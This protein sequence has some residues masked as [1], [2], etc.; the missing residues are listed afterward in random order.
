MSEH[1][2]ERSLDLV[3]YGASGFT[4]RQAAL[5][6]AKHAPAGLRWA[7]A[8]RNRDKLA[9]VRAELGPELAELPLIVAEGGDRAALGELAH[10]TRVV[11]TTAGPFALHGTALVEACVAEGTDYVDITGETVWVREL[12][13]AHHEAAAARG[14]KIVPFCGVDSVPSDI[15]ALFLATEMERRLGAPPAEVRA[16]FLGRGGLNGGTLATA[17]NGY[18]AGGQGKMR[19]PLLL[20]PERHRTAEGRQQNADWLM[21]RYEAE[22][23]SWV[24]PYVMAPINTRVVRRSA[25]LL[26]DAGGPFPADFRYSEGYEVFLPLPRVKASMTA[27]GLVLMDGLLRLPLGR[28]LVR[29]LGP[30][31][32]DGP[33]EVVMDGGFLRARLLGLTADGQMLHATF[34]AEGDPGNRVT[35]ACLCQ[36]ALCLCLQRDELPGG[37]ERGGILTPASAF[38]LVLAQRLRD[39]GMTIAINEQ[40]WG[41]A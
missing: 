26:S 23:G 17:L 38:G 2:R 27:A 41:A 14:T 32:G 4:G 6:V 37:P 33:S 20:N 16:F 7:L 40:G 1:E 30:K 28:E 35:V 8:G 5:Y 29:R 22:L 15:G 19:D 10:A 3:I 18:E 39:A 12:I 13:D 31:P 36:A 9:A 34:A 24:A 21:P 25:A 11:A